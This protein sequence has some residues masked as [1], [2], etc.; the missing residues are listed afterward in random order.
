MENVVRDTTT[1]IG[2]TFVSRFY[3]TL[4]KRL[5]AILRPTVKKVNVFG[6]L[7]EVL[8]GGIRLLIY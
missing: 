4:Y 8:M 5:L 1:Y 7:V 6:C 2:I 3:N